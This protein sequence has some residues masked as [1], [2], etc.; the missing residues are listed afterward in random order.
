MRLS[1]IDDLLNLTRLRADIIVEE[2]DGQSTAAA[3]CR[4]AAAAPSSAKGSI[5]DDPQRLGP[6]YRVRRMEEE[7]D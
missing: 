4:C 3:N 7:A 2:R 6:Q 5:Q 1:K